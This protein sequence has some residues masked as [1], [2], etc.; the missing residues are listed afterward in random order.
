MTRVFPEEPGALTGHARIRGGESQQWLIYPTVSRT[1][2]PARADARDLSAES[3]GGQTPRRVEE[4]Q[5]A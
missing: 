3:G 5:S 4:G 1:A 2:D